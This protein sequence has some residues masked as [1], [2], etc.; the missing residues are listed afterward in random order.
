M[1]TLIYEYQ[2]EYE[3]VYFPSSREV[4]RALTM[5]VESCKDSQFLQV[6]FIEVKYLFY[7]NKAITYPYDA[8]YH[9]SSSVLLTESSWHI[10]AS[11][12]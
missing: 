4:Y 6:F 5:L 1:C 12:C 10:M 8:L 3:G 2:S 7:W 11:V 9:G